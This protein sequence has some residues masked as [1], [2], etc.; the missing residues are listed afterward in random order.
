[1]KV[2]VDKDKCVGAGQCVITA[3]D[4]FDQDEDD[5]TV[6]LLQENPAPELYEEV[7]QAASLCPALAIQVIE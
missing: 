7:R 4:V 3:S 2:V 5:A 1:M 6:I